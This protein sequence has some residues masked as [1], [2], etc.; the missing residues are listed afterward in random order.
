MTFSFYIKHF[1]FSAE[2]YVKKR[3]GGSVTNEAGRQRVKD[4]RDDIMEDRKREEESKAERTGQTEGGREGGKE[5]VRVGRC[6]F[7]RGPM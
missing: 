2:K 3:G 4:L 6:C 5:A 1:L 7:G